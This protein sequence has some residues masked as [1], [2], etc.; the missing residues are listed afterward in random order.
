VADTERV[1]AELARILTE[2]GITGR[3]EG[4]KLYVTPSEF[5]K[6]QKWAGDTYELQ[7]GD[8]EA[9]IEVIVGA[10]ARGANLC[11]TLSAPPCC[12]T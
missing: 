6:L 12:G 10:N 1:A 3:R 7:A 8:P 4:R 9:V 2:A 5:A 11:P